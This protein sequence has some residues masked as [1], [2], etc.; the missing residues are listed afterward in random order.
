MWLTASVWVW[1]VIASLRGGA[2]EWDNPRYRA[3]LLVWQ[4]LV[5]GY[6]WAW[7]RERR[8]AWL[9][10]WV[11]L[12]VIFL[13]VFTQWYVSRYYHIGGQIPF[14]WMILLLLGAAAGVLLGGWWWDC[15]RAGRA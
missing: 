9:G 2:D 5:A 11:A 8:D 7:S 3:I 1:I 6:A 4:A 13:A 10:R 15:R 12:E 14:G